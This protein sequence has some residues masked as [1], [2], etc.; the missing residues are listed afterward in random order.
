MKIAAGT[1]P[2]SYEIL[3]PPGEGGVGEVY[4]AH[5]TRLDREVAIKVLPPNS[6]RT[7]ADYAASSKRRG[8]RAKLITRTF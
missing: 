6:H 3:A 4:P 2:G 5:D 7:L 1:V 8:P